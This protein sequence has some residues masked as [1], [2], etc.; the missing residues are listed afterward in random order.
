MAKDFKP[1]VNIDLPS[2]DAMI[3]TLGDDIATVLAKLGK[4]L[5]GDAE[6]RA[7]AVVCLGRLGARST[8]DCDKVAPVLRRILKED[9]EPRVK[10]LAAR[11]MVQPWGSRTK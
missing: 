5:K 10:A 4:I 9:K 3:N 1:K 11:M 8:T 7:S 6:S 2:V